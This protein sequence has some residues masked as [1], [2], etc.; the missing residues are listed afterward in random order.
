M[1][2]DGR[3]EHDGLSE[4]AGLASAPEL[5]GA[6]GNRSGPLAESV[7]PASLI[8]GGRCSCTTE[9]TFH[10]GSH[11]VRTDPNCPVHGERS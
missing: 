7:Q 2:E 1:A 4:G 9:Q 10:G 6:G 11:N 3:I 5:R 8:R